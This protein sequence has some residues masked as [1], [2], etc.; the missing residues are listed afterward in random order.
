MGSVAGAITGAAIASGVSGVASNILGVNQN[1][2][3]MNFQSEENALNRAWQTAEAEKARQFNTSERIASQDWQKGMM[4]LQNAYNSPVAMA[5]RYRDAGLNPNLAMTGATT[6]NISASPG[7]SS[8]ASSPMPSQVSGLS[9]V[10]F[11]PAHLNIAEMVNSLGN[12]QKSI[13]EAEKS[14]MDTKLAKATFDDAVNKFHDEANLTNLELAAKEMDNFVLSST[15]DA[16]IKYAW[17]QLKEIGSKIA[18]N[19]A[20]GKE[21]NARTDLDYA[22]K[23]MNDA[24]A[25]YHGEN[26]EYMRLKVSTFM[27]DFNSM[28]SVRESEKARNYGVAENERANAALTRW[29][30]SFNRSTQDYTISRLDQE[31]RNLEKEGA[32]LDWQVDAAKS[33]AEIQRVA[34]DHAEELFWK[35]FIV[36]LVN[37]GVNAF[38]S[39]KNSQSWSNMSDASQR[40]VNAKLQEIQYQHGDKVQI[41][42]KLKNGS[43]RTRYYSRPYQ[44][45]PD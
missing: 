20:S 3:M 8:P 29:T 10:S 39:I 33:A 24:L 22:M 27:R 25:G 18:L 43:T 4:D 37:E 2:R 45:Y 5:K 40:R 15:K 36:S 16:K 41:T 32:I 26:A 34:A 7:S 17:E 9:P 1:N 11:Q 14:G 21:L 28:L 42:D 35:D 12:F 13:A 38:T 6:Q 31:L 23:R 44:K 30:E 19:E